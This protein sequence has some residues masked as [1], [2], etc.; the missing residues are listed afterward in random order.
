[1]SL[2]REVDPQIPGN[3]RRLYTES[4]DF[5]VLFLRDIR[6]EHSHRSR[7]DVELASAWCGFRDIASLAS[8]SLLALGRDRAFMEL[9]GRVHV[10]I[11]RAANV[12]AGLEPPVPACDE[13]PVPKTNKS[14]RHRR[15]FWHL[16]RVI[17]L[18]RR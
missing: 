9:L 17:R 16:F 13:S 10:M 4:P 15:C 18:A 12:L 7:R 14:I 8:L 6:P 3:I 1:M 2:P 5:P 11:E